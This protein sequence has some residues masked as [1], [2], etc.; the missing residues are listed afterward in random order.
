M[1]TVMLK[2]AVSKQVVLTSNSPAT[3]GLDNCCCCPDV[4][5]Y[6]DS[7]FA[8]R[9]KCGFPEF[10]GFVSTPPKY[11]LVRTIHI[12]RDSDSTS[13]FA[14]C[15]SHWDETET[16]TYTVNDD[17]GSCTLDKVCSGGGSGTD[18]SGTFS[19]NYVLSGGNCI[20]SGTVVPCSTACLTPNAGGPTGATTSVET[21]TSHITGGGGHINADLTETTTL[22]SEYTTADL[23][24]KTVAGL[25]DY[26]G[27]YHCSDEETGCACDVDA[28]YDTGQGCNCSAVMNLSDDETSYSIQRFKYKFLF[29]AAESAFTIYWT[30]RFTP[31]DMSGPTDTAKSESQA[32]GDTE[33]SEFE[34]TEDACPSNGTVDIVN[35]R[36]S[37]DGTGCGDPS[38]VDGSSCDPSSDDCTGSYQNC[39]QS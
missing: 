20:Q 25:P 24:T 14:V 38:L 8:S 31:D 30:E 12:V 16:D 13:P 5:L 23:K 21:C 29:D 2:D 6:C 36:W 1:P 27:I 11:Y 32:A 26:S 3:V 39:C 4:T 33:S 37:L 34:V 18:F 19:F 22:S 9:T 17:D 28:G 35:I 7:I 15:T 10:G